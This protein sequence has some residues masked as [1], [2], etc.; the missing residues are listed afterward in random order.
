MAA[1]SRGPLYIA[2]ALLAVAAL[3]I[4]VLALRSAIPDEPVADPERTAARTADPPPPDWETLYLPGYVPSPGP[5]ELAAL[6]EDA[7]EPITVHLALEEGA[8]ST[9]G[10]VGLSFDARE[11]ANPM[12]ESGQSNLALTLGQLD[13]PVMRFGGNG[14]DRH[15]WWTSA[16]E[17]SP[18]WAQVTVTPEDLA[19]VA[20]VADEIDAQVTIALDL[21]HDDPQ[22]AADMAAHAQAA[23]GDRLIAVAIGNEPNGYFHPNQLQLAVR[24]EGW[25]PDAYQDSLREYGDAIAQAAPGL[26]IAGPGAYDAPWWRAFA[27]SG[28]PAKAALT[29]HWYPLWDCDGP[30]E[31][32]ANPTVE[33]LTSPAIRERAHHIIGMGA[34]V[35]QEHDLP[36]WMEET[37]PT[38]CPGTN[39]TSR[40]HAQ[41]LW[42]VDYSLTAMQLGVERSAFHSTLQACQGGAPMSPV[43]ARG[44]MDDPG[45]IVSG[46]TS[47]LALMQLGWLPDGE[48]LRSS[49]SGDGTVM[50][51]GVLGEDNTLAVVLVD[52]RDPASSGSEPVPVEISA[53]VT[54]DIVAPA[55][56]ALEE[57]SR[58]SGESLSAQQSSLTA[59]APLSHE[60][61]IAPLRR[62]EPLVLPS[63][64]GTTTLLVFEAVAEPQPAADPSDG[65]GA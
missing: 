48:L 2:I 52:M 45:E 23:F 3:I 62:G 32:I 9:E 6:P 33:D 60:A 53:P 59:L 39:D 20:A 25:G 43:C 22:R 16:G 63:E 61:D 12:W 51:H 14:V 19:R 64:A 26:P 40:T 58:L 56:W 11:L 24:D 4:G 31:S 57:G 15:M 1:R 37:G 30:V 13:R 35:T 41:A 42:T 54:D 44:P 7:P 8:V 29:M 34:D 18:P 38:S 36:L 46:R 47:F 55:G 50:A 27:E 49:A 65:G 5:F 28:L 17:S 21:G 10:A